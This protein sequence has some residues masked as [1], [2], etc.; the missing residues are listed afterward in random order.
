MTGNICIVKYNVNK[1][2]TEY[3]HFYIDILATWV[4]RITEF[5]TRV[6]MK[7]GWILKF[8]CTDGFLRK[9]VSMKDKCIRWGRWMCEW[10]GSNNKHFVKIPDDKFNDFDWNLILFDHKNTDKFFFSFW[11]LKMY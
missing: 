6:D 9:K 4:Y 1:R 2:G 11:V 5:D 3:T 10:R 7:D 8:K